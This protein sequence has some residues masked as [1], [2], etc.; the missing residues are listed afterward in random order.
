MN[1]LF[2]SPWRGC[3][4]K[5]RGTG[6]RGLKTLVGTVAS[7]APSLS[8]KQRKRGFISIPCTATVCMKRR[9]YIRVSWG[10]CIQGARAEAGKRL[11]QVPGEWTFRRLQQTDNRDAETMRGALIV[12]LEGA[13]KRLRCALQVSTVPRGKRYDSTGDG[14]APSMPLVQQHG[15]LQHSS[16]LGDTFAAVSG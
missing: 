9:F 8:P 1:K 12:P 10:A 6:M 7:W 16:H 11:P 4:L 15:L 13:S 2:W 3:C 5:W 14:C